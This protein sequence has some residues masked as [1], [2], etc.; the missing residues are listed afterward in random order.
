MWFYSLPT[1]TPLNLGLTL[2]DLMSITAKRPFEFMQCP[3]DSKHTSSP[4]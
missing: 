1:N 4:G 3:I 2:T